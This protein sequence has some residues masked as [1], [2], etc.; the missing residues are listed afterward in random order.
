MPDEKK[1]VTGYCEMQYGMP[2]PLHP[3]LND[4]QYHQH[5]TPVRSLVIQIIPPFQRSR[6]SS[7]GIHI[8]I[9]AAGFDH[10]YS[11]PWDHVKYDTTGTTKSVPHPATHGDD[12]NFASCTHLVLDSRAVDVDRG[13]RYQ[14]P[15]QSRRRVDARHVCARYVQ[16]QVF[17]INPHAASAAVL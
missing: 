10:A 9:L 13:F 11:S 3:R 5:R 1:K 6:G 2:V 8:I 15:D 14:I 7:R 17:L 16:L 4:S 12:M